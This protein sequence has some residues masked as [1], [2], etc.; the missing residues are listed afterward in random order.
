MLDAWRVGSLRHLSRPARMGRPAVVAAARPGM[1]RPGRPCPRRDR[2]RAVGD[3]HRGAPRRPRSSSTRTS[4]ASRA[5]TPLV[6]DPQA[7][8]E[9]L[10][11]LLRRRLG[12]H[13]RTRPAA[14]RATRSTRP[15]PTSGAATRDELDPH[16]DRVR[17][18]AVRAHGV[19]ASPPR[20]KPVARRVARPRPHPARS[21]AAPGA[22][23]EAGASPVPNGQTFNSVHTSAFPELLAA[24]GSSLLVSTYQS[25]RVI[26]GARRRNGLNT[27]FR[28]FQVPMGMAARPG[29][30][31][32][33]TKA[34]VQRFQN[35]PALSARLEPPGVHDACFVPRS[36]PRHRRHPHPRHGVRRRRALGGQH[37]LLVP[38]H[39]HRR[40]QLRAALAAAVRH[41]AR[42]RGPLPPQRPGGGRR[43]SPATSPPSAPPTPTSGWRDGQDDRG[44]A[45]RRPVGRGRRAAASAC[46]T[47]RAGT[48]AG[49]GCSSRATAPSASS[50]SSSGR[51]EEVAGCPGSPAAWPSPGPTPSS[52]SPRCARALFE[53]IPLKAEGV[54]RSCGVWVIDLRTGTIAAFLRFEGIVQELFEVLVAARRSASRRSSSPAPTCSTPRSSSRTPPSPIS[55]R[56]QSKFTR[57]VSRGSETREAVVHEIENVRTVPPR[58]RAERRAAQRGRRR[59]ATGA[60]LTAGSRRVGRHRR[61]RRA[62]RRARRRGAA[63]VRG[64]EHSRRRSRHPA[65]GGPRRQ[66]QPGRRHHRLHRSARHRTAAHHPDDRSAHGHRQRR[67]RGPGAGRHRRL[68]QRHRRA[69]S[70][71]T[72]PTRSA[73]RDSTSPT[74]TPAGPAA[75]SS[76]SAATWCSTA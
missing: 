44:R 16:F 62:G 6:R 47:R 53:G 32:V 45:A 54:E 13:P 17:E 68:G 51:F 30:L 9:R 48:T 11:A 76:R 12:R 14:A 3:R 61:A 40:L 41:R 19:F 36:S 57:F 10:A 39:L 34:Q 21:P 75:R 25:G 58:N 22:A 2:D 50:T 52:A 49:S 60:A 15:I 55:R 8:M 46:R 66:R 65:P 4:G 31:A 59:R 69:S 18:V 7:E 63:G 72:R 64:D 5:T 24:V 26:V 71:S 42:R 37:P 67:H 35:Q 73:S 74:G 27:H 28:P 20:I 43:A 1:A 33:G 56:E 38:V 23:S 70:T 29:E